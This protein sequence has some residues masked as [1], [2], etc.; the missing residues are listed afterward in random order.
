MQVE[1]SG[2]K[3]HEVIRI[4]QGNIPEKL[5]V[6]ALVPLIKGPDRSAATTQVLIEKKN[7]AVKCK[8]EKKFFISDSIKFRARILVLVNEIERTNKFYNPIF[9]KYETY[10]SYIEYIPTNDHKAKARVQDVMNAEMDHVKDFQ[11][12]LSSDYLK[13]RL[14]TRSRKYKYLNK[15]RCENEVKKLLLPLLS[16]DYLYELNMTRMKYD[17]GDTPKHKIP[18]FIPTIADL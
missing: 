1:I 13:Q 7:I 8:C 17:A 9:D 2:N 6:D 11:A 4:K 14:Q 16:D 5:N 15:K 12:W 18:D 10:N 3:R